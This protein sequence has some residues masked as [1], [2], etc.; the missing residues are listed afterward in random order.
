MQRMKEGKV[1]P[2]KL[3][4]LRRS[5][6]ERGTRRME[7]VRPF[8]R[9]QS[10]SGFISSGEIERF[11]N[12]GWEQEA[13]NGILFPMFLVP[14]GDSAWNKGTGGQYL[15]CSKVRTTISVP[16]RTISIFWFSIWETSRVL[17]LMRMND[18]FFHRRIF[19]SI[20]TMAFSVS[21]R[22]SKSRCCDRK[23]P[24][25]NQSSFFLFPP[26]FFTY[27]RKH[28]LFPDKETDGFG[29]S[30]HFRG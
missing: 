6:N 26:S 13:R 23:D 27:S 20:L 7:H 22:P 16:W 24:I 29:H 25:I 17:K 4:D 10:I 28:R 21:R 1:V 12:E 15:H 5:W 8:F 3:S 2:L 11:S 19:S 18:T 9:H 14:R 30:S